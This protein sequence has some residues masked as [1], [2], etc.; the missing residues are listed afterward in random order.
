MPNDHLFMEASFKRSSL[1][2]PWTLQ[3][4]I[5]ETSHGMA[6]PLSTIEATYQAIQ[7]KNI[8]PNHNLPSLKNTTDIF[9]QFGLSIFQL[10]MTGWI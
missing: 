10:V 1:S 7:E 6:I 2:D 3:N 9:H 5:D 8:G 4:A